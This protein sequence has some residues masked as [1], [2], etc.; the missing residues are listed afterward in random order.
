M[1]HIPLQFQNTVVLFH[2]HLDA[3]IQNHRFNITPYVEELRGQIMHQPETQTRAD[4][5]WF[6]WL[7]AQEN[8][9]DPLDKRL[10]YTQMIIKSVLRPLSH[11][12]LAHCG[13]DVFDRFQ[14]FWDIEEFNATINREHWTGAAYILE[15]AFQSGLLVVISDERQFVLHTALDA[16]LEKFGCNIVNGLEEK[17]DLVAQELRNR[18]THTVLREAVQ[19]MDIKNTV[20]RKI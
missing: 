11:D 15:H 17:K 19:D 4:L 14:D 3:L 16:A 18:I 13:V 9:S 5:C 20:A 10:H 12:I 6:W 8:I 1:T 2:K 7:N